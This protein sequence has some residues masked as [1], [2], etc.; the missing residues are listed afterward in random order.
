MSKATKGPILLTLNNQTIHLKSYQTLNPGKTNLKQFSH[1]VDNI[2]LKLSLK[3]PTEI[4]SAV[5]T[6]TNIIKTA[7]LE[8]STLLPASPKKYY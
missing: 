3:T 7:I 8:S 6:L 4:D 2:S 1:I 5:S